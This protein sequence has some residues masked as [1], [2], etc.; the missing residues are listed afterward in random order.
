MH[1]KSVTSDAGVS[2]KGTRTKTVGAAEMVTV[3]GALKESV[4][5]S[6]TE[7]VGACRITAAL[8]GVT[9][10]SKGSSR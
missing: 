6:D 1:T 10:T 3:S 7:S 5:G 8:T 9:R 4:A 2:V